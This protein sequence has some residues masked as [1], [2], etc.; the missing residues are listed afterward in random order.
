MSLPKAVRVE[1]PPS[2]TPEMAGLVLRQLRTE[3]QFFV[4]LVSWLV[5]GVLLVVVNLLAADFAITWSVWPVWIWAVLLLAHGVGVFVI[6][7][8]G[9]RESH[10]RLA[11]ELLTS[12]GDRGAV[13]D[14]EI[15]EL[16]SRLL[17]SVEAAREAL[18]VDRPELVAEIARGQ[19]HSLSI[20]SWLDEA[21]RLLHRTDDHH[22]LRQEVA[23][24][25]SR[26]ESGATRPAL[27]RLHAQLEERDL[28]LAS[29]EREVNK[30]R[31]A[32]ESFLLVLDSTHLAKA[33][34]EVPAALCGTLG[35]RVALLEAVLAPSVPNDAPMMGGLEARRIR[36]EVGL[37]QELQRTLLPRTAPE[38]A[39]LSVAFRYQPSSEVGGDFFD[40]Y[41][42]GPGRL[43][44]ALGDASG[45]GLDS[46]MISSMAKSALYTQ[47][48][49]GRS[50]EQ[51]M[52]EM[53][54]M[55]CDTLGSRRLMTFALA[56]VD[57]DRSLLSW[58]NAG[59]VFPFL[60]RGD[61]VRE[62]EQPSY[63]LGVR[64]D[65]V[66]DRCEHHLEAGDVLLLL[67]D[68]TVEAV[69]GEG[70]EYGWTRLAE[71]LLEL[72]AESVERLLSALADDLS[73]HL[74]GA[75]PQDDVTMVAVRFDP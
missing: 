36:Q 41:Q 27:E 55:M 15:E 68:G 69:N 23:T 67:T 64:A 38:I 62:L 47:V 25:L 32:L 66:Y 74:E 31:S 39:G 29:L 51:S 49:N 54:R 26:P 71:R 21:T 13:A 14:E 10:S 22:A 33:T 58:V 56:E 16:R 35:E 48:A 7:A 50:L 75:P 20:V 6:A 73:S 30:R 61:R 1:L 5:A 34:G 28:K 17:G 65:A 40:F 72:E 24:A 3:D 37:A 46:S 63:P 59:Q 12:E 4:H 8:R 53:N 60:R 45:H 70:Q 57:T 2:P 52:A 9:T 44:I 19:S 43:L 18:R 42:V 11:A